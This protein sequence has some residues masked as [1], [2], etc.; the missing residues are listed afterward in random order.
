MR[1]RSVHLLVAIGLL[2]GCAGGEARPSAAADSLQRE[3]ARYASGSVRDSGFALAA[4]DS[5]AVVV[6]TDSVGVSSGWRLMWS[7]REFRE[8]RDSLRARI[9]RAL[10]EAEVAV[11]PRGPDTLRLDVQNGTVTASGAANASV[12]SM[13]LS[14]RRPVLLAAVPSIATT[15]SVWHLNHVGVGVGSRYE[16]PAAARETAERVLDTW[17]SRLVAGIRA[18]RPDTAA[19]AAPTQSASM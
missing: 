6:V 12:W 15:Q 10:A 8:I 5:L 18:V 17:M 11:V 1:T 13:Q 16:S 2:V 4:L 19:V 9:G 7:S 14:L 3:L